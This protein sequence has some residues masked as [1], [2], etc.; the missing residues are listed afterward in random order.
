MDRTRRSGPQSTAVM[1][2]GQKANEQVRMSKT[3]V[4]VVEVMVVV[5]RRAGE[6]SQHARFTSVSTL[7]C[8]TL[9]CVS[10]LAGVNGSR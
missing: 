5:V 4:E 9:A 10:V 7:A 8:S 6:S 3:V 2:K 1:R